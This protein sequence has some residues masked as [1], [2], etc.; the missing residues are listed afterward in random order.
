MIIKC[1]FSF[2]LAFVISF[3]LSP[4]VIRIIKKFKAR[5]TI[6]HYVEGHKTKQ[7]TPTMGGI[8][9]ILGTLVSGLFALNQSYS[10]ALMTIITMLACGILGFMDDYIK[11]KNHQNEGLLPYQ[12]IIG[13]V[14][15]GAAISFFVY[16]FVGS[17]VLIPI[18]N[19]PVDIGLFII[20][21]VIILFIALV[22]SVNLI[23]GLDGLC[24]G[25]SLFYLF[26]FTLLLSLALP[27]LT[28]TALIENQNLILVCACL[29]GALLAFIV[30]NGYPA[31]IF[32]GD[33]GSLAIGGFLSAVA[34]FTGMELYVLILGL[35]Y[36]ITAL[37]DVIQVVYFK[38]TK[39]RVFLMAPLHHHFEKR[40]IHENKIVVIYIVMTILIAVVT[41]ILTAIFGS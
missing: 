27:N 38:K 16:N 23:D 1:L 30:Y 4:A 20:P 40:G 32:M 22:N 19:T 17:S 33:T 35:P 12:K 8:I 14:G 26:G 6:L 3:A 34:V 39:K 18:V 25:V 15:I 37:S 5:Q 7:G 21:L 36:V 10:L 11:I 28:A 41:Y 24:S 31:M 29:I 13:Q 9:F 2:L